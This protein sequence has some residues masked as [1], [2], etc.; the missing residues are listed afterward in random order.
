[1]AAAKF[2]ALP[3]EPLSE[4]GWDT[5]CPLGPNDLLSG[6]FESGM[7]C[8]A[9]LLTM[10]TFAEAF[11]DTNVHVVLSFMPI[12]IPQLPRHKNIHFPHI[13]SACDITAALRHQ[14]SMCAMYSSCQRLVY[15]LAQVLCAACQEAK[16]QG[17]HSSCSACRLC[18]GRGA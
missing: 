9:A 2:R 15:A 14:S 17:V 13:Y 16:G 10:Q 12:H 7:R 6:N 1:M 8:C 3:A 11:T 18:C 4:D 5:P